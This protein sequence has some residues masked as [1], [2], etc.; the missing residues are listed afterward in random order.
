MELTSNERV[1]TRSIETIRSRP[2]SLLESWAVQRSLRCGSASF[3]G[4][5]YGLFPSE[6]KPLS[7]DRTGREAEGGAIK[8]PGSKELACGSQAFIATLL[9][10]P[11]MSALPII[12]M[13]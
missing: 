4:L 6:R 7:T 11:S 12:P 5:R 1:K 8:A 9:F 2:G 10:D 3:A 13:Q